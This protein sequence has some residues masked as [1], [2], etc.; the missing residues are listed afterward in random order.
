MSGELEK[1]G[2]TLVRGCGIYM[3]QNGAMG[4]E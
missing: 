1:V 3:E 2:P 4:F